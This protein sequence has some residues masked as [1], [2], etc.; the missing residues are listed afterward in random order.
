[1]K[2]DEIDQQLCSV[3]RA[4]AVVGERWT[5]LIVRDAFKGTRR[6]D[7]FQRSLGV[8]RHRLAERLNK[9]VEHGVM[10]KVAYS[11][12]PSRFEY[13]LTRKGLALYPVLA[14]LSDWGD[15]WMADGAP[16]PTQYRHDRCGQISRP[17]L[18]CSVCGDPLRPEEITPVL[19]PQLNAYVDMLRDRLLVIPDDSCLIS[20][21]SA[22]YQSI[23]LESHTD[24]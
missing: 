2:W 19:G 13:R 1:M 3:A 15:Q 16:V 9:L 23:N 8:T 11:E 17:E 5:L 12:R 6:F 14:T 18:Q 22:Y 7:D 21:A 24:E 4:L 10:T 20:E